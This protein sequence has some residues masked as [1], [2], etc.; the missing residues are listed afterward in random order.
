MTIIENAKTKK[1]ATVNGEK[2]EKTHTT[3]IRLTKKD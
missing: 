3:V 2:K 1:N